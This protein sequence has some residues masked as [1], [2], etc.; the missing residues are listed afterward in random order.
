MAK[1][2]T[3]PVAAIPRL[4]GF[5]GGRVNGYSTQSPLVRP[6]AESGA[7]ECL[8]ACET[9]P[10]NRLRPRVWVKRFGTHRRPPDGTTDGVR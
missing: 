10:S 8:K 7:S 5:V 4:W 6:P 9:R 3:V 1:A 2:P